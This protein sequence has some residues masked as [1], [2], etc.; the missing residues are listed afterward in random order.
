MTTTPTRPETGADVP[1]VLTGAVD[2]PPPYEELAGRFRPVF[3]RIAE[4][5]LEREHRRELPFEQVGWLR[6][7][8]FGALRVA[9][10]A[11]GA[12]ASLEQLFRLLV[13]LAHADSNVAHL[14]RGHFAFLEVQLVHP[15]PGERR[16]WAGR[17][18]AGELVGN[19]S[20]EVGNGGLWDTRTT[21]GPD[22]DGRWVLDGTKY[23]STGSIFA[24]WISVGAVRDDGERVTVPVRTDAPG[25][26]LRDDWDGFGQ[27]MTGSGTTVLAGVEVDPTTVVP[28][29]A[30]RPS[31]LGSFFQ[32]FLLATLAGIGRAV[33]TD[34]VAFVRPRT[35]TFGSS[36]TPLPREDPLV[37]AVVGRLSSA[38]WTAEAAVLTAARELDDVVRAAARGEARPEQYDEADLATYRAQV[39]VVDLVLRAATELF[40]VGGASATSEG[41]RLDRHWRNARTVASHNPVVAKQRIVGAWEVNGTSPGAGLTTT[42]ARPRS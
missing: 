8:G 6:D 9:R 25:V 3:A 20:S 12:G 26:E 39:V 10:S 40:E 5:A 36:E 37:L 38:A 32:L 33:V 19:A 24:D 27:R 21:V 29:A 22:V 31:V 15:D 14:L 1:R 18:V 23:Y 11:G 4:G 16:R 42:V 34:A 2:E 35:R 13:E 28:Y 7:A 41:R 17:A 30:R